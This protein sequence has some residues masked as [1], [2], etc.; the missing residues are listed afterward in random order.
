MIIKENGY[1]CDRLGRGDKLMIGNGSYG[2]RG[3]LDEQQADNCV[4]LNAAGFYDRNGGNWR[5][6]VNMPNPLYVQ[7]YVNDIALCSESVVDH[8]EQLDLSCGVYS[9]ATRY[10]VNGVKIE[11]NS[12]RFF[13]QNRHDL[14]LSEWTF[15]SDK[16]VNLK[17]YSGIDC[18]VW[19]ISGKHFDVTEVKYAPLT[20]NAVTNEGKRLCVEVTEQ[21]TIDNKK[22]AV[23]DGKYLNV[24]TLN[25][26]SFTLRKF[27]RLS[28]TNLEC[29]PYSG[30]LDFDVF[31][32]QNA[33]WWASKWKGCRVLIDDERN[34]QLAVDYSLYQLLC[35]APKVDGQ[36]IGARGLSGQ[37]YKGA[38]FWDTEMFMLPF[39]LETD[40]EVAKRLVRYR[41][42]TLQG[43]LD[44]AQ[45][46]GYEGAFYAWES[47]EGG[48]DACSDFN[49]TD[50]FTNRPVR[51]Y[52]KDK[53]IHISA[54]VAVALYSTYVKTGDL[55]LLANGGAETLI[56]CAL[57]YDSYA[58][59][60]PRLKRLELLDVIG[61]DEYHE[62]V[63]NNAYTN[64]MAHE[65]AVCCLQALKV[66]QHKSPETYRQLVTKYQ[67][68]IARIKRFAKLI[69]LPQPNEHGIIE[70]FDGYFRLED[71]QVETVRSRLAHPNEYWGGSNG[72]ATA[73]RVIKQADVIA[74]FAVLP[75]LFDVNVQRANYDFYLPYTEHG[76]S[77]SAS[78][79]SLVACKVGR[80]DDS[81][82]WFAKTAST[83]LVGG[84]KKYAGNVYIGGLHPA[85]CGGAWLA[86]RNGYLS[87]ACGSSLPRQIQSL[88]MSTNKGT[89]SSK[90][91]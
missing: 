62:R 73:T 27:C 81:Y 74:L 46:Y 90:R 6:T 20:V 80:A 25:C 71:V 67:G 63:N 4:A 69:Y 87:N 48:I 5:E 30:S 19:N 41:I 16:T 77:L 2:Y 18:D 37:T 53:Q 59:F 11:V 14:L 88:T 23:R 17:V 76:S 58:Y 26:S 12:R 28:H 49:V 1:D 45:H 7:A 13:P 34:L 91:T 43:A 42:D 33:Q 32:E 86:M 70:Q 3:T 47:Q 21:A 22:N 51:T 35:Y 44:K 79:Y 85:A 68:E 72:V 10:V 66:L 24:Y 61:P 84:G 8:S 78:M 50:V 40:V 65:T 52:F 54:D 60:N 56:Q 9:R 15:K 75:R 57:F 29:L 89:I 64:Y 83:D 38:V 36:S 55:S 31:Y 39:Y 82:E